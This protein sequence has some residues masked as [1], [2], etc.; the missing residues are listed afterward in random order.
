MPLGFLFFGGVGFWGW[1]G[2]WFFSAT[3]GCNTKTVKKP[4]QV[5]K[6]VSFGTG[7]RG[8]VKAGQNPELP[9]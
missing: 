7:S 4:N 9:S 3:A 6:R 1:F 2:V 8:Q 5:K